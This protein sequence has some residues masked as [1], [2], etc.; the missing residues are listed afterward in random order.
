M[1]ERKDVYNIKG[2]LGRLR[3]RWS[4]DTG[5]NRVRECAVGLSVGELLVAACSLVRHAVGGAAVLSQAAA[6]AVSCRSV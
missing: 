5:R 2:T 4:S 1:G 3:C 6:I